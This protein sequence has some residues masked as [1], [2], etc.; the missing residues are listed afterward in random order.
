M[1]TLAPV[2]IADAHVHRLYAD[3]SGLPVGVVTQCVQHAAALQHVAWQDCGGADFAARARAF[4]ERHEESVFLQ[5]QRTPSR[6]V[7]R[8]EH[9]GAGVAGWLPDGAAVLDFGGGL[10]LSSALL[11]EAG[12][13]VTYVDVDGPAAAFARWYFAA[14]G[15]AA[16]D[17]RTTPVD[18][19]EL[20]SGR[21]FDLVLA[22]RVLE[23]V[24]DPVAVVE[25]LARAL[26][27]GGTLYLV[28]DAAAAGPLARP[29]DLG[30]LRAGSPALRRL[31]P[32][33]DAGDGRH[34]FRMP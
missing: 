15:L 10:G 32:V 34:A 33:L 26:R 23:C 31:A 19:C 6:T 20:P 30:A 17:V 4:H 22:E 7:R 25:R 27:P 13:T 16:I 9:D 14:C 8:Q 3:Y 5:L 12:H 11:A 18:A 1:S 2:G 24:P 21:Q 29:V 28:L